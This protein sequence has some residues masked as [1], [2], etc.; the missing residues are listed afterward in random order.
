[1]MLLS[2]SRL[3]DRYIEDMINVS[4]F[5]RGSKPYHHCMVS[6]HE[7]FVLV[8]L[9]FYVMYSIFLKYTF[10]SLSRFYWVLSDL[11][12]GQTCKHNWQTPMNISREWTYIYKYSMSKKEKEFT[13]PD[14]IGK[15]H[16]SLIMEFPLTWRCRIPHLCPLME[17]YWRVKCC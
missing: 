13:F 16:F 9:L 14:D 5:Y 3:L 1:M 17:R 12:Q 8:L 6:K 7:R 15:W 2:E 4:D 11:G 10:P